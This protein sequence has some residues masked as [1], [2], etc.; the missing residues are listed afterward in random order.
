[1]GSKTIWDNDMAQM[2]SSHR[3]DVL[4]GVNKASMEPNPDLDRVWTRC[5][6]FFQLH[7]SSLPL[8][9]T[10]HGHSNNNSL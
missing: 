4:A 10:K 1:M 3:V 6:L 7:P 2:L 8:Y 9:A 5:I